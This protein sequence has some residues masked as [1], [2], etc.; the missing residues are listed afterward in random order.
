MYVRLAF[1]V[2]AHLEPD[3]LLVDEVLAVGDSEFQKKCLG[4]MEEITKGEGRTILFVSHNLEAIERLCDQCILL[5]NGEI[6]KSG[7]AGEVINHYLN[8]ERNLSSVI[9]YT[10]KPNTEAQITKISILDKN[11][12]PSAQLPI[13]D[14]F[15]IAIEYGVFREMKKATLCISIFSE[16]N[17]RIHNA[18]NSMRVLDRYRSPIF[19]FEKSRTKNEVLGNHKVSQRRNRVGRIEQSK[20]QKVR[21]IQC[22]QWNILEPKV[23]YPGETTGCIGSL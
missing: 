15:F 5:R 23:F 12:K 4:K 19:C 9:E 17:M 22:W 16:G 14:E 1:S 3:I 13:N 8:N 21:W 20:Q 7:R 11:K 6:I 2:A 10:S 18:E